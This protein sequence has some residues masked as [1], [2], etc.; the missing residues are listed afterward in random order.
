[1][2]RCLKQ[3]KFKTQENGL[4]LLENKRPIISKI[5]KNNSKFKYF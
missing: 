5:F 2:K 3:K 1:M 4:K